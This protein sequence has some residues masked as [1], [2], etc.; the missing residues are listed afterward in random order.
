VLSQV[1]SLGFQVT[2]LFEKVQ[3]PEYVS[4]NAGCCAAVRRPKEVPGQCLCRQSV[5]EAAMS[6]TAGFNNNK[7]LTFS[8][9][10][11]VQIVLL[12]DY[13]IQSKTEPCRQG[14]ANWGILLVPRGCSIL[15][16]DFAQNNLHKGSVVVHFLFWHFLAAHRQHQPQTPGREG[17]GSS[18]TPIPCF[19]PTLHA[20]F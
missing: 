10:N 18:P 20:I 17:S 15:T 4:V 9:V 6:L 1:A 8:S 11:L 13:E 3:R 2:A 19:F 5:E 12:F 7:G 16:F 14:K